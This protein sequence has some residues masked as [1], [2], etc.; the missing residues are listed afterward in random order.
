MYL[1]IVLNGVCVPVGLW[2]WGLLPCVLAACSLQSQST[3][4]S[5]TRQQSPIPSPAGSG[6]LWQRFS[7]VIFDCLLFY[8]RAL[9][10][11]SP[12]PRVSLQR[13]GDSCKTLY[14]GVDL[15]CAAPSS[16][17]SPPPPILPPRYFAEV[18]TPPPPPPPLSPPSSAPHRHRSAAAT[19]LSAADVVELITASFICRLAAQRDLGIDQMPA[20][21]WLLN[22]LLF[23]PTTLPRGWREGGREGGGGRRRIGVELKIQGLNWQ[24]D[25][26]VMERK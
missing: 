3:A 5:S 10:S 12:P 2:M 11:S 19:Q 15:R 7:P 14:Q 1:C 25:S 21:W 23:M 16:P 24:P 6:R 20:D 13:A 4:H 8:V 9:I 17:P 18:W 22:R 26:M